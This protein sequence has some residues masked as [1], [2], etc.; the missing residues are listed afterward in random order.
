ESKQRFCHFRLPG[1]RRTTRRPDR[2]A[3]PIC[4]R[5]GAPTARYSACISR[6]RIRNHAYD[7][8]HALA[9]TKAELGLPRRSQHSAATV[10]S[11]RQSKL[12]AGARKRT[13]ARRIQWLFAVRRRV[14]FR[15][16]VS[17]VD[18]SRKR[19]PLGVEPEKGW[20]WTAPATS[21]SGSPI[22]RG[23]AVAQR[24]LSHDRL[25]L[26]E[27]LQLAER[28]QPLCDQAGRRG[29]EAAGVE[30]RPPP[31]QGGDET[32]AVGVAAAR[33]VDRLDDVRGNRP[34]LVAER[35][36]G[37]LA[38]VLDDAGARAEAAEELGGDAKVLGAGEEDRL[39]RAG[40]EVVDV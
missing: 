38:A 37:S 11:R 9:L 26:G 35:D 29:R 8:L 14:F 6:R 31:G 33:G 27:A 20:S 15:D 13:L 34:T 18:V 40:H 25:G 22:S 3:R 12:A 16:R 32:G 10:R 39:G 30:R 24:R 17:V 1:C 21:R 28:A 7:H 19:P 5:R 4:R 36:V 2:L 23:S